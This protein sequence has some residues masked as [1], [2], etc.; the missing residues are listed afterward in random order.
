M[1]TAIVIPEDQAQPL[2]L[3]QIPSDVDA[4]WAVVRG[5]LLQLVTSNRPSAALYVNEE[6]QLDGLTVNARATALMWVHT[7]KL[8]SHDVIVGD[9]LLVGPPDPSGNKSSVPEEYRRLLLNPGSFSVNVQVHGETQWYGNGQVFSDVFCAYAVGIDL[10][11]RWAQVVNV[12]VVR[13]STG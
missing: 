6:G 4:Y 10:A 7:S 12:R 1:I 5:P 11:Q 8:R 9:A 3:E 2:H 13:S